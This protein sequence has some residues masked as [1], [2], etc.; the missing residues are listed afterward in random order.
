MKVYLEKHEDDL[1][2]FASER[3]GY[4]TRPANFFT[5]YAED[6]NKNNLDTAEKIGVEI[7]TERSG[8]LTESQ[9]DEICNNLSDAF[10]YK[11][12]A[13]FNYYNT[14]SSLHDY[15]IEI[16]TM[17]FTQNFYKNTI[18][19]FNTLL[20]IAKNNN[21]IA[22]DSGNCGIHVHINRACL[23]ADPD[24]IDA[25]IEKI[26]Y[27]FEYYKKELKIFSRRKR[28]SYAQF[29]SDYCGYSKM[30]KALYNLKELKNTSEGHN[31]AINN[32]NPNTLEIR[33]FNSTLRQESFHAIIEFIFSLIKLVKNNKIEDCSLQNLLKIDDNINLKK[34][35]QDR[36]IAPGAKKVK[37]LDLEYIKKLNKSFEDL[38]K[39]EIHILKALLPYYKKIAKTT[40]SAAAAD[41]KK[42]AAINL[43]KIEK[44]SAE[45]TLTTS[46]AILSQFDGLYKNTNKNRGS[47]NYT[48]HVYL[49]DIYNYLINKKEELKIDAEDL[50]N[51]IDIQAHSEKIEKYKEAI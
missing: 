31:A 28:W 3:R 18:E 45:V 23:G 26:I 41:A 11:Y 48:F 36:N 39:S 43:K 25:N 5:C 37:R 40:A 49:T 21:L 8:Y 32:E 17:P 51:K 4:H 7:E 6:D 13:L 12:N 42:I 2:R 34:Y 33:I 38:Q 27:F 22:H 44:T 19:D 30:G 16:I 10:N 24:E 35:M 14:D 9:Y 1:N 46:T 15:G 47:Y 29:A 20:N 50:S